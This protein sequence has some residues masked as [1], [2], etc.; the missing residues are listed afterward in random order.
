MD[1]IS[2]SG[3]VFVCLFGGALLGIF[4]RKILPDEHLSSASRDL[5]KMGIGTIATMTALVLGL[6][7]ASAKNNYDTQ[8]RE[9]TEMSAKIVLLDRVLAHYGPEANHARDLLRNSVAKLIDS[10]WSDKRTRRSQMAAPISLGSEVLFD[11][12]QNLSPATDAQRSLQTRALNLAVDIGQMRWLMYQQEQSSLSKPLL[13]VVVFSFMI[14]FISF[15]LHS[16]PNGTIV[17]TLF[18]CALSV[19]GAIFLVLEMYN[20]YSG[21]IQIPSD[22]LRSALSQLGQ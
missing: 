22:A 4:L 16:P 9:M 12:I 20:P 13:T 19:S 10:T 3:T 14:S 18:L 5:V 11:Q 8:S 15:S 2:T 21:V 6:L 17:V 1:S 7:V